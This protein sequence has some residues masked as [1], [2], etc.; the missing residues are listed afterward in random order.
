MTTSNSYKHVLALMGAA[1]PTATLRRCL[2]QNGYEEYFDLCILTQT[3]M[4]ALMEKGSASDV[5]RLSQ[6][7]RQQEYWFNLRM[8]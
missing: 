8:V 1:A 7:G 6:E 3:N 5:K 4:D 2:Q